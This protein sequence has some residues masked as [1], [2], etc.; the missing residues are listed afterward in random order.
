MPHFIQHIKNYQIWWLFKS[1]SILPPKESCLNY[2]WPL[3]PNK[4]WLQ[5]LCWWI[6]HLTGCIE[7]V[8][9]FQRQFWWF[10]TI[11]FRLSAI[12]W[13]FFSTCVALIGSLSLPFP[14]GSPIRAVAPPS[15]QKYDNVMNQSVVM[16]L[17]H[18]VYTSI[19]VDLL[20]N[21][22]IK[23]FSIYWYM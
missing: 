23:H 13:T 3:L 20:K 19:W 12:E 17:H 18:T 6:C 21:H 10:E 9:V 8:C 16:I 14:L 5:R 7:S 22:K 15:Y 2:L 1:I 4:E 11:L